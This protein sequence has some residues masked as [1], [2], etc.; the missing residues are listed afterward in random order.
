MF[1]IEHWITSSKYDVL[2]VR[3]ANANFLGG[4]ALIGPGFHQDGPI[5]QICLR[6]RSRT[7]LTFHAKIIVALGT[8]FSLKAS[9]GSKIISMIRG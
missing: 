7:T 1:I 9:T 4:C 3:D 6:V 8:S 2:N 5:L